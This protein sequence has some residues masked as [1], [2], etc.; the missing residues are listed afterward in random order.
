MMDAKALRR[1]FIRA[2]EFKE[3]DLQLGGTIDPVERKAARSTL[4]RLRLGD[5]AKAD[6]V[7]DAVTEAL[8]RSV[9]HR[10]HDQ[11]AHLTIGEMK[12]LLLSSERDPFQ[13]PHPTQQPG[14]R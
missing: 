2:N 11:I 5:I 12:Q 6:L 10:L 3:G 4:A 1:V 8:R 7:E 13:I 9:N 14:G